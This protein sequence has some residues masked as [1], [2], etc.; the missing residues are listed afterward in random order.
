MGTD[1]DNAIQMAANQLNAKGGVLGKKIKLTVADDACDPQTAATAANQLV[2]QNVVG[3][4]GGYCSGAVLPAS[5]VYHSAGMPMVVTAANSAAI[6][7]QGYK[8]IFLINGTTV[9]QGETAADYMVKTLGAKRIAILNDNSAYSVDLANRTK[10]FVQQL[11]GQVIAFDAIN[12]QETDFTTEL[13]KLKGLHPDAT[14]FTGYYAAGGLLI[15]QFRQLGVSGAFGVGDGANDPTLIKIA[16]VQ[17]AQNVFTTTSPTPQFIPSAKNWVEQYQKEFNMAPGPYS[18]LSYDGMR[19]MANAIKRAGSTNKAAII[20]ALAATKNFP[21]FGGPV[22]F[23]ADGEL[24]KSN[25]IVLIIKNGQY[26]RVT[27]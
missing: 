14:Y 10:N 13:T 25:F 19:L 2:S 22:S 15:K 17:N 18:A 26:Q 7:A 12:P 11:G 21:T 24:A 6:P 1:M 23:K 9:A 4:V 27:K 20:K 5:G 8:D 3:V 16:G